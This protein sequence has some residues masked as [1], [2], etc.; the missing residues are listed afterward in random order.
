MPGK[1]CDYFSSPVWKRFGR[2][3]RRKRRVTGCRVP[4]ETTRRPVEASRPQNFGKSVGRLGASGGGGP[5][6]SR[7]RTHPRRGRGPEPRSGRPGRVPA[8]EWAEPRRSGRP[9]DGAAWPLT[10]WWPPR[11]RALVFVVLYFLLRVGEKNKK[12]RKRTK[13][14]KQ[15][16]SIR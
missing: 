12:E 11:K 13:K 16:L 7:R 2:P 3:G 10:D 4:D 1:E 8:S 15:R 6:R 5:W 9:V 14:S